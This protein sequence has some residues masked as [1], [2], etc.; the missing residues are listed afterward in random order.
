MPPQC[1]HRRVAE[2]VA[3]L[4]LT[5][6]GKNIS[7]IMPF[8]VIRPSDMADNDLNRDRQS[9]WNGGT[10]QDG[11][12]ISFKQSVVAVLCQNSR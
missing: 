2:V 1:G 11:L 6:P 8:T 9:E 3:V 7:C 12:C 5:G 4:D 10:N